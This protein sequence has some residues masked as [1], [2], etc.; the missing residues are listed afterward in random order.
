ML[1]PAAKVFSTIPEWDIDRLYAEELPIVDAAIEKRRRE[2]VA[3]RVLGRRALAEL[4][5]AASPILRA[6][7]RGP[8]WPDGAVGSI[9][10]TDRICAVAVAR[11]SELRS[12]GIDI[13]QR[14]AMTPRMHRM[15]LTEKEREWVETAD[16]EQTALR[17]LLVFSAKEAVYK[18]QRP[19]TGVFLGFHDVELSVDDA[20]GVFRTEVLAGSVRAMGIQTLEGKLAYT[21]D[22]VLATTTLPPE[23]GLRSDRGEAASPGM[24]EPPA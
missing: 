11:Q 17:A 16:P 23:T 5:F 1:G 12:V 10:H 14:R 9:T 22:V 8:I 24:R 7:D 15:I 19:L 18:C 4:G 6:E 3:G 20:L 21:D 2:F 13:E